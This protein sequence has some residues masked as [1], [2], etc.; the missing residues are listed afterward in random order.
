MRRDPWDKAYPPLSD[1]EARQIL[2]RIL[3]GEG[4]GGGF[5]A[6][7]IDGVASGQAILDVTVRDAL[8]AFQG[9]CWDNQHD[10]GANKGDLIE[11]NRLFRWLGAPE[12]CD[13]WE[14]VDALVPDDA[15]GEER[16][17]ARP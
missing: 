15:P 8:E 9:N 11:V 17:A 6:S 13:D 7:A 16:W 3:F 12:L 10:G 4:E 5:M 2:D 14:Q 1:E